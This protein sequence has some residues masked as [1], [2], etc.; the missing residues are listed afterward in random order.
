M[1]MVDL[2]A[3]LKGAK[4]CLIKRHS[5][6][7]KRL[8]RQIAQTQWYTSDQLEAFQLEQ[9]QRLVRHA[10][11]TVPYYRR[12]MAEHGIHPDDIRRL[13]DVRR[14]PIMSKDDLRRAGDEIVSTRYR[15]AFLSTA[16]TGG[17]TGLPVPVKRDPWSIAREH[18]FVRRQFD[19]AGV[20]T[21]DRCAYLEGRTV[22]PP[23][24]RPPSYHY[25]D[26]VMRELTLS[27]FHLTPDV[28]PHYVNLMKAYRIKA[29]I[30][31]PSAAYVLAKGCLDRKLPLRL[32][33]VLTTSETLDEVKRKAIAEAFECP[34]FDFYGSTERVCYI[35]TCEQGAYHVI[36]EYG[37]TEL[38]PAAPPNED[39]CQVVSTGFWSLTMPLI[40]YNLRDLVKVSGRTCSC[41]RAF[42]VV[43]KIIGRD[44]NM[45]VTPSG[46]QLGASAI[47]CIL[48]RILYT[49]YDMP[50][51]AGRV[52][53]DASDVLTLEYVPDAGFTAGHVARLR[54][55]MAEQ[56]P[57]G[58][59]AEFRAL[60]E[61]DRTSR[62]KFVSFVMAENH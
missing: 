5:G 41:G 18:A 55:V 7:F 29:L 44:G 62:G 17:T 30:A 42:T 15:R 16:H 10:W 58:M 14:F 8:Y 32:H 39:C 3:T 2:K 53:Q 56:V 9:F 23:G 19:W 49:M 57:A 33:C 34:V 37:L 11:E 46:L 38:I 24:Q 35:H 22:A 52:V 47:E 50:I 20:R 43:D 54:A 28:V 27:A 51:V 31:Y 26:A 45:I 36:P 25:Y 60:K 13:E 48:A 12:V 1:R 40:R 59:R 61:M 21:S 4:T 6:A